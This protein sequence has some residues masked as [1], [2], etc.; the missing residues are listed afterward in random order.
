MH[1]EAPPAGP[2]APRRLL[3]PLRA[4]PRRCPDL[5]PIEPEHP[6][7]AEADPSDALRLREPFASAGGG[8][9]I[10]PGGLGPEFRDLVDDYCSG[11]LDDDGQ[12]RLEA[13]LLESA[14]ARREFV[15]YFQMHTELQFAVR[16]RTAASAALEQV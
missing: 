12:R 10:G 11:L 3:R 2:G 6:Q 4:N 13:C 14:A 15:A 9:M 8:R 16:A 1:E 7:F 5:G